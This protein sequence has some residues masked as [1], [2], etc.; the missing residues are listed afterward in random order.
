MPTEPLRIH[1][2]DAG[3]LPARPPGLYL[4]GRPFGAGSAAPHGRA[5]LKSDKHPE[6]FVG[7]VSIDRTD[8]TPQLRRIG[9][10]TAEAYDTAPSLPAL[11]V[12]ARM[13][14]LLAYS[15]RRLGNVRPT[16]LSLDDPRA[17]DIS[18]MKFRCLD[19]S[20]GVFGY[21]WTSET[22]TEWIQPDPQRLYEVILDTCELAVRFNDANLLKEV[23]RR[24]ESADLSEIVKLD[25]RRRLKIEILLHA[26]LWAGATECQQRLVEFRRKVLHV[27][28]VFRKAPRRVLAAY[29]GPVFWDMGILVA[30]TQERW[31]LKR[32][33]VAYIYKAAENIIKDRLKECSKDFQSALRAGILLES[34]RDH[35]EELAYLPGD[36]VE[37]NQNL[38][39]GATD[40]DGEMTEFLDAKFA[41][42]PVSGMPAHLTSKTGTPWDRK[43]VEA[44]RGRIRR[45]GLRHVTFLNDLATHAPAREVGAK[46]GTV[47]LARCGVPVLRGFSDDGAVR[48]MPGQTVS[49]RAPVVSIASNGIY[50]QRLGC[51]GG[52]VYAHTFDNGS[53]KMRADLEVLAEIRASAYV[54]CSPASPAHAWYQEYARA[55]REPNRLLRDAGSA[56]RA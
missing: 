40:F 3:A 34:L 24:V 35:P 1:A 8:L 27:P 47:P 46:S 42:V 56:S 5:A 39:L 54:Q 10:G 4:V 50:R 32:N 43:K 55:S 31:R 49:S 14:Y 48:A 22:G 20:H 26:V 21:V 13:S 30:V 37:I 38:V 23:A 51:K 7:K 6:V 15:A 2:H 45:W 29:G 18:Q 19:Y 44:A 17:S 53:G 12:F 16:E 52:W 11:V 41:G 33:P 9:R 36:A 25:L 28:E